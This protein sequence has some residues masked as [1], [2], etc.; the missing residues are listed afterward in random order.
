MSIVENIENGYLRED[1]PEFNIGDT[2]RVSVK[3][4]EGEKERTQIYEG[5]V[6]GRKGSGTR[7]TFTVR[8]VSY[9]IGVERIFPLHSKVVENIKVVRRGIVRRSKLY[10]LRKL[11]GKKAR[12]KEK[13]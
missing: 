7:E 5:V 13:R 12:I 4:K 2:I 10:Y 6:I 1:V 3:V 9:G 11:S 8:R